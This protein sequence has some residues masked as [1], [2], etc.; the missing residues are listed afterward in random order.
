MKKITALVMAVLFIA[1]ALA[2]CRTPATRTRVVRPNNR[3]AATATINPNAR[4]A[5]N[6]VRPY[7]SDRMHRGGTSALPRTAPGVVPFDGNRDGRIDHR[8]FNRD[9]NRDGVMDN[10]I[11][12]NTRSGITDNR[13]RTHARDGNI[14]PR[15]APDIMPIPRRGNAHRVLPHTMPTALPYVR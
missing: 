15:T 6:T 2:A 12:G 14:V 5:P 13:T 8:D 7:A 3:P 10:T 1:I 9:I 11:G 4:S